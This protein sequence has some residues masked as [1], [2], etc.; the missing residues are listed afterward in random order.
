MTLSKLNAM[1]ESQ[2]VTALGWIFENSPWVAQ[3]T[4][5]CA[6][7]ETVAALHAALARTLQLANRDDQ[8]A[9]LRAHPDLGTRARMSDVSRGNRPLPDSARDPSSSTG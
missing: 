8:L 9:L 2:F 7:F 4:W 1:D 6:P 5:R 3:R